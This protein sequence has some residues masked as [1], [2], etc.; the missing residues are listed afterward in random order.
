MTGN[1][2]L[3]TITSLAMVF[4]AGCANDNY[5]Y[6]TLDTGYVPQT[7]EPAAVATPVVVPAGGG[8]VEPAP[9]Y[10]YYVAPGADY[11]EYPSS[12]YY[13]ESY[14]GHHGRMPP[15]PPHGVGHH[16]PG[17]GVGRPPPGRLGGPHTNP[18]AGRPRPGGAPAGV[19]H[20]PMPRPSAGTGV[21]RPSMPRPSAGAGRM[22]PVKVPSGMRH[23]P[24]G[25]M[26][27]IPSGMRHAPQGRMPKIPSGTRRTR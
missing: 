1:W 21:S 20:R 25:S 13:W 11:Y 22:P 18:S 3:W 23:A 6:R 14:R 10:E 15:P 27:K 19:G 5:Y 17:R 7:V 2:R 8:Y 16:G 4:A 26:P 24:Q 9:V 12:T